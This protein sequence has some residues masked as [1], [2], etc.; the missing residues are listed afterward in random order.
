M[1]YSNIQWLSPWK[2]SNDHWD[3]ED[4]YNIITLEITL[5]TIVL[6]CSRKKISIQ[7]AIFTVH[8]NIQKWNQYWYEFLWICI[9]FLGL[10]I[11]TNMCEKKIYIYN[12]YI[13]I[14]IYTHTHKRAMKSSWP[15]QERNE[16]E[17]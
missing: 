4:T 6:K 2:N 3:H 10:M 11:T 9:T 1:I 5:F 15:N 7:H 14:Y 13:Y 8:T 17:P 16:R 12:I